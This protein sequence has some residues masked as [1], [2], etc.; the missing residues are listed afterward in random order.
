VLRAAI[1]SALLATTLAGAADRSR[2][3]RAA[4][5]RENPCPSTGKPRGPCPGHEV[6]HVRALCAGGA[7][8]RSNMAWRR[9]TEH[10]AKTQRDVGAC[11]AQRRG[12]AVE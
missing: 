6:D 7:G 5:V 1:C 3:E 4:F 10:K 8:H 12:L 2:A 9:I 11:R